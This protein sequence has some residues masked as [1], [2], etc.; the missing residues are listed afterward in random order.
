MTLR[1]SAASWLMLEPTSPAPI[2]MTML[3][4]SRADAW[5]GASTSGLL[6]PRWVLFL[7]RLRAMFLSMEV[8]RQLKFDVGFNWFDQYRKELRHVLKLSE[9]K[10][11]AISFAIR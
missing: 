3:L 10:V 8:C 5:P 2:R 7:V 1:T 11:A 4:G 9:K 6:A